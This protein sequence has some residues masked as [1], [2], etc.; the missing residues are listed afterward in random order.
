M[1]AWRCCLIAGI[2][3]GASGA[4]AAS[5]AAD[6][7]YAYRIQVH[8]WRQDARALSEGYCWVHRQPLG[9]FRPPP[10]DTRCVNVDWKPR[11][12]VHYLPIRAGRHV[13]I[14]LT[15]PASSVA[16]ALRAES[17]ER[18][19]RRRARA[20]GSAGRVWRVRLPGGIASARTLLVGVRYRTTSTIA[21][22]GIVRYEHSACP[23]GS[24]AQPAA[25]RIA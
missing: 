15:E 12:P 3:A 1:G 25:G 2:V 7:P 20:L 5:A 24:C 6:P 9:T 22:V 14:R 23:L 21:P 8:S 19:A 16:V 10:P 18:V 13:V 17:G 4:A 11:H